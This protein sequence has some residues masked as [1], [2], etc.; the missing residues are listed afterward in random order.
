MDI[1]AANFMAANQLL[2]NDGFGSFSA[3]SSALSVGVSG[4][5]GCGVGDIDGDGDVDVVV[6]NTG[7]E[8]NQLMINEGTGFFAEETETL[9]P[10]QRNGIWTSPARIT[11]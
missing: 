11:T 4:T 9:F 2:L 3:A 6:A 10:T 7:N 8:A 5:F 1:F